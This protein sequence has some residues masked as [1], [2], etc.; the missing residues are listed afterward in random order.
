M[1]LDVQV[2][3]GDGHAMA[4]LEVE[5]K[6]EVET[7]AEREDGDSG[8]DTRNTPDCERRHLMNSQRVGGSTDRWVGGSVDQWVA[9]S[10]S[11]SL[12]SIPG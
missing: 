11:L 1:G 4:R 9:G 3:R 7:E 2:V 6:A 12:S 5:V 10:I 8:R